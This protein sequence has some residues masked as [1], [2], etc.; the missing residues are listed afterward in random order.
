[1]I[2]IVTG[3]RDYLDKQAVFRKLSRL[4]E[5][6]RGLITVAQGECPTGADAFAREWCDLN[7]LVCVGFRPPWKRAK[8][9]AGPI[10]NGVM[11]AYMAALSRAF[12]RPAVC[13]WFPG[14]PGGGTEN[15]KTEAGKAGIQLI[16]G[17]AL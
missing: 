10:R 16:E 7:G 13:V 2:V 4:K 8:L 12:S 9:A 17:E 3:G 15:M 5:E 6:N 1:M 14:R 11:A